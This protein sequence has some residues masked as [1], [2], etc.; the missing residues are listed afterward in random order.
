M[1]DGEIAFFPLD[2]KTV[3][4]QHESYKRSKVASSDYFQTIND[5]GKFEDQ[6]RQEEGRD[7]KQH[8]FILGNDF[9]PAKSINMDRGEENQERFPHFFSER[10]LQSKGHWLDRREKQSDHASASLSNTQLSTSTPLSTLEL[11]QLKP[12][13]RWY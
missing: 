3:R 13:L 5:H 4:S 2:S 7:S 6:R 9:K 8:C 11:F 12:A 1:R 10:P